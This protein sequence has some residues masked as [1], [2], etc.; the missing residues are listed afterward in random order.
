MIQNAQTSILYHFG[1]GLAIGTVV[2]MAA[3]FVPIFTIQE[4]DTMK[5]EKL[6]SGSYRIRQQYNG[7]R[8]CVTVPYKPTHK[9]ALGLLFDRMDMPD[10]SVQNSMQSFLEYLKQYIKYCED[11][12]KSPSTVRGYE[13]IKKNLSEGFLSKRFSDMTS[14][15]VQKEINLYGTTRSVKSVKNAYGLIRS[16]FAKYRPEYTLVVKLPTG[17]KKSEYEPTTKDVESILDKAKG[18]RYYIALQLAVL[19]LRR[20]EI[21]AITSADLDDDNILTINKD[22]ILDKNHKYVIKNTA[23]TETSNRRILLPSSLADQLR[24]QG[25][26]FE[27][28]PHTINQYLH[29]C[30]HQ[31]CIPE[32]RLHMLRHFCV[33]YLHKQGFTAEQIMQWGGWSTSQVMERAYRYNLDPAESQ[34]SMSNMLGNLL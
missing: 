1:S 8:Y 11:T 20:G 25:Y 21:L 23:K 29:R 22:M 12:N 31:L 3:I 16:V 24:E 18:S 26:A 32:F 4:D 14:D 27:G 15:D 5:I 9:E 34:K 2:P 13:S 17:E 6:P 30:Q 33:A 7:K 28:N 19:G 10:N